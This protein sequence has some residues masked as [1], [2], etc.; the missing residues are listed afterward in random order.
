MYCT[1][2]IGAE[3]GMRVYGQCTAEAR[4]VRPIVPALLHSPLYAR[5]VFFYE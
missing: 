3:A 1:N 2:T 4:S 5:Y